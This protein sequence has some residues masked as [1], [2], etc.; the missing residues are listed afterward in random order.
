MSLKAR[1]S[2]IEFGDEKTIS[3]EQI[4]NWFPKPRTREE[5]RF[6]ENYI[7]KSIKKW[8]HR[9]EKYLAFLGISYKWDDENKNLILTSSNKIGLVPL[10]NPYGGKIYGS[11]AVKPRLRWVK[12]YEILKVIDWKYQPIFLKDEEPIISDG[13]LPRWFKAVDTLEAI[14]RAVCLPMKSMVSKQMTSKT[15]V[16]TI[17]WHDYSSKSI[18][19]GKYNQFPT[20][21]T[22]C[23]IDS[24]VHRQ[25]KGIIKMIAHDISN[26]TVPVKVKCKAKQLIAN[27]EKKLENVTTSPPDV[28]KIKRTKVPSFYRTAY[29]NAIKKCIEYINQSRFSLDVGN[30]YGLP[31]SIEM[32][33]LFEYWIEHWAYIFA[34][35]IGARFYSD[36]RKNSKIRFCNLNN[37]KSLS[38]IKPDIIIEKGSKTLI[39]EVKYKK[40]LIYLQ[41]KKYS[42]EILEE[43]RRDLH[44]LLAYMSSSV[45]EK[46]IGCLI[47]PKIGKDVSNQFSTLIN[48]TNARANVD[49]V[50][51]GVSFKPEELL[52]SLENIWNEKYATFF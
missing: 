8:F 30:F 32:D 14:F 31:W 20:L 6:Y 29:E 40:H 48:Y 41:H 47:Y 34:K 12:I 19:Y 51:C 11:I 10:R 2:L 13:I 4:K 33:R 9:N 1:I 22:D 52:I 45:S 3:I 46:R 43:H 49:V 16:G 38:Q 27:I 18:P 28:K 35:R 44:Q 21:I 26:S 5:G 25:F 36:L 50:L 37:W 7:R 39:I 23:S 42:L 15:P 17:N 24:E